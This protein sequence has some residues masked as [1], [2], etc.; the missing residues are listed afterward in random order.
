MKFILFTVLCCMV[1][2]LF[3]WIRKAGKSD[4]EL[5]K[6]IIRLLWLGIFT[7]I[8]QGIFLICRNRLAASAAVGCYYASIDWLIIAMLSYIEVYTQIFQGRKTVKIVVYGLAVLDTLNFLLNLLFE[9]VFTLQQT[10]YKGGYMMWTVNRDTMFFTLHLIF[11]YV[12]VLFCV[13]SLIVKTMQIPSFYWGKYLIVLGLLIAVVFLNAVCM[14]VESPFDISVVLYC[15][16][17]IQISYYSLFYKPKG[18]ID[19]TLALVVADISDAVFCFDLWSKCVYANKMAE[20]RFGDLAQEESLKVMFEKRI[21]ENSQNGQESV[22][23]EDKLEIDG[24]IRVFSVSYHKLFDKKR[25]YIGC[26]FTM[27]DRTEE[28]E[29]FKEEHYRITHDRLTG[30]YNR[31]YFLEVV[32][33][34][35]AENPYEKYSMVCTNIKGFKLY[36]DLFGERMGDEVLKAEAELLRESTGENNVYGRISGDEFAI[37]VPTEQYCPDRFIENIKQMKERFSSS[38]YQM[39]IHIGVYEIDNR[40]EPVSVMCDKA[41]LAIEAHSGDY[42]AIMTYY[43]R[44]L[45]EK[46]LYER[47]IVGEFDRALENGEFC[48]FLQP[49]IA[50][51]GRLLGAEALVRWQHPER[52]LVFPGDFIELFEKTGLI[53]RLDR[54]MWEMAAAKLQEW[55]KSGKENLYISVNISAKDFYY[56]D[57]YKEVTGLVEKYGISPGSLKLEITETVL[58]TEM[59][60]QTELLEHLR[61]YG[62]QIE[63]DDFGSG[64]SSLNML[65]NI[66]VDVVK[67]DMG[68]LDET[69][70]LERGTSILSSIIL[71]IKKLGMGV[72]TEGVETKEQVESLMGMGCDMFQGYYFAKPMPVSAFEEKYGV[73]E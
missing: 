10:A 72:I 16:L 30:L 70:R 60:N 4:N 51:D 62:F 31:E 6:P 11:T 42:N 65:K 54:Y 59:R 9:H 71:L 58:M 45:L 15:L 57:I 34:R 29:K 50:S 39:H 2:L 8:F 22:Q 55:K 38:Q 23:Y 21:R 46:S 73:E 64:Y 67:I 41:K 5:K 20:E 33:K 12:I 36:N 47:K 53:Y 19:S 68:F 17:G 61:S 48:M 26:F 40:T 37:F 52:G 7:V 66:D 43:D 27:R 56:M 69:E 35:L 25:H 32:E 24:K 3:M 1:V 13:M 49:Q 28:I 63:I 44:K 18:L 14:L